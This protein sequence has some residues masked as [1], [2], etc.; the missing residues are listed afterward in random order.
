MRLSQIIDRALKAQTDFNIKSE[1]TSPW[2][3]SVAA[4]FR[5]LIRIPYLKKMFICLHYSLFHEFDKR[6][7]PNK[8]RIIYSV[9]KG[10]FEVLVQ[11]LS[12]KLRGKDTEID[13]SPM[14]K[15]ISAKN[16]ENTEHLIPRVYERFINGLESELKSDYL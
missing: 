13:L 5:I 1:G 4:L 9:T 14:I 12:L 3:Q 7:D 16:P 6:P 10:F 2:T 11:P 8:I 15:K